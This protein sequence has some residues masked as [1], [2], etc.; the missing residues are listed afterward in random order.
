MDIRKVSRR[1]AQERLPRREFMAG[2]RRVHRRAD[3]VAHR[4]WAKAL[5]AEA[6]EAE[7]EARAES[8]SENRRL[9]DEIEAFYAEV[10]GFDDEDEDEPEAYLGVREVPA[11][12]LD[13]PLD[14][15]S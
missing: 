10:R 14:F 3:N 11:D 2:P 6:L 15:E 8:E 5:I 12:L 7:D 9:L 4:R 13:W 1:V